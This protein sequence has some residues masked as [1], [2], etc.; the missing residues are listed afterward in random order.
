MSVQAAG[1][2]LTPG[3]VEGTCDSIP[4][5]RGG[6]WRTRSE[7]REAQNAHK[8]AQPSC[9]ASGIPTRGLRRSGNDSAPPPP[10]GDPVIGY[11]PHG[12]AH[13]AQLSRPY[14][15]ALVCTPEGR[16]RRG[17]RVILLPPD[18]G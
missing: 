4:W 12:P 2:P 13:R 9:A 3:G 17:W 16:P 11:L 8:S 7:P 5:L 14:L 6:R 15:Y 10:A 18:L 1:G